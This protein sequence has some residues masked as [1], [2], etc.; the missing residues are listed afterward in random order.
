MAHV[1]KSTT[2]NGQTF[3]I[4]TGKI[5]KQA[6]GSVL[7]R[8]GDSVVLVAATGAEK[9]NV[10]R[11]FL[12]LT[13]EYRPKAAAAGMIPGGYFK[14]EGRPGPK[15]ILVA[16]MMDRPCRPL[17]PKNWRAEIQLLSYPIS[18]DQEN[19]TDVLALTGASAA[20]CISDIPF[21]GPIAGVRV[22]RVDGEWIANPTK[23]QLAES[24]FDM[25]VA[26]SQHAITMVEGGMSEASETDIVAGLEFGFQA[27]QPLIQLQLDLVAEVGK[28][29]REAPP[30]ADTSDLYGEIAAQFTDATMATFSIVGKNDRR[31]AQREIRN[32][33]REAFASTSD[34]AD[35]VEAR[36]KLI[37]SLHEKLV[38]NLM[39]GRV[40]AEGVRLDGRATDEI[41]DISVE[42]GVLPRTH[43]SAL[44]TRGETQ[45][46]VTCTLGTRRDE[47]RIDELDEQG[48][49]RF[50][51][52]YNFPPYS[53]GECRRLTGAGRREI[54]HGA[55]ARRAVVPTVPAGDD[56]PYVVRVV[57]DITESNGSSS[58]ASVCGAS[59]AMMDASVPVSAP[60]AGIAMGLIKE[61]DDFAVLSDITGAED[62]L[63]DMDF[64]VTGTR[65]GVTAFQMDTKIKGVTAEIMTRAL[66]QA[67]EGRVHIL[68]KMDECLSA[69]RTELSP[70]APRIEQ[71]TIKQ[72]RIRDI[73]GPGGKTI[74][75]MQEATGATI[76]V[77]DSGVVTI[78]SVDRDSC[79]AAIKM[80]RELTQEAEVGKL[81]LGIVKKIVD[82][83]AFVEIFTGTDGLV[84]I[85]E[86]AKGRVNKVT[87]VL[88]EGDEVLVKCIDV[89]K[90]GKIRLSR[91]A[92][93]GDGV[94]AEA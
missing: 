29:K 69:P 61:G 6:G 52:H 48:W 81:Y 14:R 64:K 8:M 39:R 7:V 37:G 88:H 12:P 28:A 50:M 56:Y 47:Q 24:D 89:D 25:I 92:A 27:A 36:R 49:N 18:H 17:F 9:P 54:G 93:Q 60:V 90:S 1:I 32:Q 84:H 20:T 11:D 55:L 40:I 76:N 68:D 66:M 45:A 42:A 21:D 13:C 78:A 82:F 41:R 74:K 5:A 94:V 23:T 3:S 73:I 26:S 75:G 70:Y 87:D 33:A 58:M 15:S 72:D 91:R 38:K 51:L 57:S 77:E 83:G 19:A 53:V 80:V 34:D 46:L 71:I 4:E 35:E 79:A 86:L 59:I 85:S 43:G 30:V 16:R 2:I 31:L 63:G 67:R 22:G 44:F 62:H 65:N 10:G